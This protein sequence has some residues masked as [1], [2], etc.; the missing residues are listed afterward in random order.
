M[1]CGRQASD[2]IP[3]GPGSDRHYRTAGPRV[4]GATLP[5]DALTS[6]ILPGNIAR[7]DS[8]LRP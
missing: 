8:H 7:W 4:T 6:L 3:S 5:E 2:E 1:R